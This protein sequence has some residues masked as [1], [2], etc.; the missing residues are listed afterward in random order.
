[1]SYDNNNRGAV[2][3]NDKREKDTHPHWTGSATIDGVEYWV[4]AWKKK[5]DA[6]ENA[7]SISFTFKLK[8][9][10]APKSTHAAEPP[11]DFDDDIPF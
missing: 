11:A 5:D 3:K 2:W 9:A 1:M 6:G 7:P 4:N 10:R 8:E